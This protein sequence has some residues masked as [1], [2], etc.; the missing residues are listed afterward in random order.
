[1]NYFWR[2][3]LGKE[4]LRNNET[5]EAIRLLNQMINR[6]FLA[7]LFSATLVMNSIAATTTITLGTLAPE[8]TTYH[9][10]LLELREAWRKALGGGVNKK[11]V[12][13]Q[14]GLWLGVLGFLPAFVLTL[15]LYDQLSALTDL[16]LYLTPLRTAVVFLLTC[17][18]CG[19]AGLLA[20]R[21][22]I[23]SDPAEVF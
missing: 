13:G 8:G 17:F 20:V 7:L 12:R 21:K 15:V 4:R 11:F 1:M 9:R 6:F 5:P 2:P 14:Q 10:T 23:H 16:P 3:R 22:V 19:T 18:M